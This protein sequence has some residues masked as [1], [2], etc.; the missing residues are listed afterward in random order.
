MTF[1]T[2]LVRSLFFLVLIASAVNAAPF[3]ETSVVSDEMTMPMQHGSSI[4][5]LDDG[6]LL[7]SWYAG[8]AEASRDSRVLCR[9]S[10]SGGKTWEPTQVVVGQG[11]RAK[12][13]W[14]A[15]KAVGN[16]VLFEKSQKVLW[17]FYGSVAFGGWSDARIDYKTSR[18][19]GRTWSESS[20]LTSG[21]GDLPRSKPVEIDANLFLPL[22]HSAW[23]KYA[24]LL[25]VHRG[26]L[27]R[28]DY[29][30]LP[31]VNFSHPAL[32]ADGANLLAFLR[33]RGK[34]KLQI[35]SFDVQ[36]RAWGK[37]SETNVANPD[38]P[39]DALRLVDGR[40]LLAAN[41]DVKARNPLSIFVSEDNGQSFR[42]RRDV[43]SEHGEEFAYPSLIG[44]RDGT[45]FLSYTWHKRAAIKVAHFNAEW[46]GLTPP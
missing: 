3:C 44:A 16:T 14:F 11:E 45:F 20:R 10:F 24:A 4:V 26:K 46:L 9:R 21:Y 42:K 28:T 31:G 22:S 8:T 1:V 40:I 35:A 33:A 36:K 2:A 18:D 39:V 5:E 25:M 12:G 30:P 38:S 29:Y 32:V 34:G 41:D 15:N 13:A 27:L 37:P 6:S 43:E 17:L 7:V 23:R 19:G